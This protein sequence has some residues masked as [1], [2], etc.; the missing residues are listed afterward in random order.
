[1]RFNKS[2]N[3]NSNTTAI[4]VN[5]FI[6]N[7]FQKEFKIKNWNKY[8]TINIIGRKIL[9]WRIKIWIKFSIF[10]KKLNKNS[11]KNLYFM[12]LH[13]FHKIVLIQ[14]FWFAIRFSHWHIWRSCGCID[15]QNVYLDF[16]S[17]RWWPATC[18]RCILLPLHFRW[19]YWQ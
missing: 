18:E 6:N 10:K 2:V 12:N 15:I 11:S 17:I 4:H 5:D 1:M 8:T 9:K 3:V 13:K 19:F 14:L 16:A 7:L